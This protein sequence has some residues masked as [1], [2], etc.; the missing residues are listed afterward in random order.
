MN[1]P[2]LVTPM[3]FFF[4]WGYLKEVVYRKKRTTLDKLGARVRIAVTNIPPPHLRKLLEAFVD[5][6]RYSLR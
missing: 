1:G 2:L 5:D 6:L 3:I 4:F